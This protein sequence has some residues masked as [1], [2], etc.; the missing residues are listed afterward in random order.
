MG[1]QEKKKCDVNLAKSE[2]SVV[3]DLMHIQLSMIRELELYEYAAFSLCRGS[4]L[5]PPPDLPT[6]ISA[7]LLFISYCNSPPRGSFIVICGHT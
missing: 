5:R 2:E 1:G 7:F 3:L 4:Q 6:T